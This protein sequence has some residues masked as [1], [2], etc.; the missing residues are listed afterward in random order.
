VF[1]SL[2]KEIFFK[3]LFFPTK[4]FFQ[5]EILKAQSYRNLPGKLPEAM[6][7]IAGPPISSRQRRDDFYIK[8]ATRTLKATML[9]RTMRAS[10]LGKES[11]AAG[12][13]LPA[14]RVSPLYHPKDSWAAAY[15]L[16]GCN[17]L[18]RFGPSRFLSKI[19]NLFMESLPGKG[20]ELI[21]V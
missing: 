15:L 5:L 18:R 2:E 11:H 21:D 19:E 9:T 6:K 7:V 14:G 16:R 17:V 20:G 1:H 3:A 13:R 4:S 8:S 10:R 12:T